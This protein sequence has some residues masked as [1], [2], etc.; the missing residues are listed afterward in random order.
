M[1]KVSEHQIVGISMRTSNAAGQ[2]GTDIPGL[3]QKWMSENC[4][5]SIANKKGSDVYCIYTEYEGDHNEPYTVV[6]GC[7]VSSIENLPAGFRSVTIQSGDYA[8]Y[9]SKGNI[10][11]GVIWQTW[12]KIWKEDLDR[13]YQTDYEIYGAK[14]QNPTDATVEIYVGLK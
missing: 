7:E 4:I 11:E 12:D 5:E 9:E 6:I 8:M 13:T 3:W 1:H 10:L 2:A 14:A